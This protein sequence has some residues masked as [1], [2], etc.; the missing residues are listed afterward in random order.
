MTSPLARES[1]STEIDGSRRLPSACGFP[2]RARTLGG[3]A[4]TVVAED[5]GMLLTTL[6]V[7]LASADCPAGYTCV[8]D[9][10]AVSATRTLGA[11]LGVVAGA[12]A[13][14]G[15]AA[16]IGFG[17]MELASAMDDLGCVFL[18]VVV[19][20]A[21]QWWLTPLGAWG[22]QHLFGGHGDYYGAVLAGSVTTAV[23]GLLALLIATQ[24]KGRDGLIAASVVGGAVA[25]SG[26]VLGLELSDEGDRP[27]FAIAPTHGGAMGSVSFRF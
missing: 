15:L 8:S 26:P 1:Q 19:A 5:T 17:C 12:A 21:A 4:G 14:L 20:G 13:S 6:L 3:A 18:G 16:G 9:T 22:G 24:V 23:G 25:L 10:R 2:N 7:T 27:A 11:T